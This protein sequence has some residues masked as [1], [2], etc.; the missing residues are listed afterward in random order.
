MVM[1]AHTRAFS[2]FGGVCR[3]GSYDNMK[4][5]AA[6]I[7][8]GKERKFNSRFLGLASHYLFDLVACTPAA[9]WEKGQVE[10]QVGMVRKRFFAKRRRFASFE[11]LNEWLVDECRDHAATT[12]HPESSDQTVAQVFAEEKVKLLA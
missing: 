8:L 2:F 5:V 1:D 6:K 7:L 3:R 10:N 12:K 9:G 11:E 4:T